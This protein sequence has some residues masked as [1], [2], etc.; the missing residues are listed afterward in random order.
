MSDKKVWLLPSNSKFY[1]VRACYRKYG[2]I[3]WTQRCNFQK[4][5]YGYIYSASPDSAIIFRFEVLDTDLPWAPEMDFDK[6][7]YVNKED[8]EPSTK[9]NRFVHLKFTGETNPNKLTLAKLIDHGLKSAPQGAMIISK[10][11]FTDLLEFISTNF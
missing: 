6:E 11:E 8:F 3:Y 9:H 2:H 4:G 7:F 10:K 5:D 1:D